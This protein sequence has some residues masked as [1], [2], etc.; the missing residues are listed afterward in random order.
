[1]PNYVAVGQT[2]WGS[3]S[4]VSPKNWGALGSRSLRGM[5]DLLETRPTGVHRGM[6]ALDQ[7]VW[8]SVRVIK[9]YWGAGPRSLR[10]WG[11]SDPRETRPSPT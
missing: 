6:V 7:T 3:A 2:V 4:L 9:K 10:I 5:S 8:A 1:M 11:V